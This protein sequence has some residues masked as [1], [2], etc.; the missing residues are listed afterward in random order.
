MPNI[1]AYIPAL[2]RG[3]ID[4]FKKYGGARL[5]II[6]PDLLSEIPRLER[7]IRA[8]SPEEAKKLIEG[9]GIFSEIDLLTK[10]NIS[11][12]PETDI[13]MPDEEL[14]RDLAEKY[15]NGR[16]IEFVPVFLRWDRKISTAEFQVSSDRVISESDFDRELMAKAMDLSKKSPDF[17]R[18]IGAIIIKDGKILLSGWN[19]PVPSEYVVPAFGDPRSNFDAGE[20]IEL[21]KFVHGEAGLIAGA[22]KKGIALEGSAI[23]VTTFPCPVCAKSIALSGI[24][25]VYYSK[26]YSLLDA[27]DIL[28]AYGVEIVLVK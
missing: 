2:H 26:G 4:F 5:F 14:C 10:E 18:Q 6:G 24:K 17:W 8:L 7:D 25:K 28:K 13:V 12:F 27:E 9:L 22:A 3:Y 23:Y 19:R 1:I 15:L 20:F 21:S 11:K 16:K